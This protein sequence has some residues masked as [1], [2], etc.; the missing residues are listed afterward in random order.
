MINSKDKTVDLLDRFIFD[1]LPIRGE[2]VLLEHTWRE[3]LVRR[4]YP[5][6]VEKLLGE[7]I[8]TTALLGATIKIE[9]RLTVQIQGNGPVSLLVVQVNH[10]HGIRA[11]AKI[12]G[13]VEG[14]T[15]L[16]ELCGEGHVVIT[17]DAEHF[18]QPYQGVISLTEESIAKVI[19]Y[20]FETS[21]QLPTRLFLAT[22]ENAAA[23]LMIQRLP[24]EIHD[25]DLF[26]RAIMLAETASKEELLT[27]PTSE[28]L[29]RLYE[30]D[31]DLAVRIFEPDQYHFECNCSKERSLTMLYHLGEEE[32][33][34]LLNEQDGT[35]Y[36]D[37]E[38]CG[39]R[40]L[41]SEQDVDFSLCT[42]EEQAKLDA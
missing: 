2:R 18:K 5:K 32:L 28:L 23:G 29:Y 13:D 37:C 19:E 8:A 20:Y 33:R 3:H 12:D 34:E 26:N 9:G 17:I 22:S 41:F 6:N 10:L 24:G 1:K 31:E 27:L 16:K 39:K 21:E 4:N 42:P 40:Y 38:F 15:S 7:L 30:T 35:V 36:V 11:T 14:L 25:E